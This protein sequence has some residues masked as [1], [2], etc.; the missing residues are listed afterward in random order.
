MFT[1][2][3]FWLWSFNDDCR[4][5][6]R[7]KT[8]PQMSFIMTAKTKKSSRLT[9]KLL[10]GLIYTSFLRWRSGVSRFS[11]DWWEKHTFISHL[12]CYLWQVSGWLKKHDQKILSSITGHEWKLC[13]LL[14]NMKITH[15]K[16]P[17]SAK[18]LEYGNLPT[19]NLPTPNSLQ[20]I[21]YIYFVCGKF[22]TRKF[23]TII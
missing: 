6:F 10:W 11:G 19:W 17:T 2:P 21:S 12:R 13:I 7:Y 18:K 5:L 4:L 16:F 14:L 1:I 15:G 3:L 22:P 20:K 8:R 23:P 9:D